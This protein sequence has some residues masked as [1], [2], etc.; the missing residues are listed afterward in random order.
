ML[1][2]EFFSATLNENETIKQAIAQVETRQQA[3]N[4][5][6]WQAWITSS[7]KPDWGRKKEGESSVLNERESLMRTLKTLLQDMKGRKSALPILWECGFDIQGCINDND[8]TT[9][10]LSMI[11][12]PF[13]TEYTQ[14]AAQEKPSWNFVK[15]YVVKN[16]DSID[17]INVLCEANKKASKE[18]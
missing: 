10:L 8:K 14:L 5:S 12:K 13:P 3:F 6:V 1:K 17:T 4:H 9:V 2:R 18:M 16:C 15:N 11:H 7:G